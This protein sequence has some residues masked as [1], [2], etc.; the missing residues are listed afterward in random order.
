MFGQFVPLNYSPRDRR[1]TFNDYDH[2]VR[3]VELIGTR[4]DGAT[5][6]LRRTQPGERAD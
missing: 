1:T 6:Y 5:G 4:Y 3:N 2:D